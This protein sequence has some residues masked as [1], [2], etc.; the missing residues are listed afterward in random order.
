MKSERRD[1]PTPSGGDYSE[2]FYFDDN[3]NNVDK[4]VATK[5]VIKE[6]REDG[7][8]INEIFANIKI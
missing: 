5:A 1:R 4:T 6:C 2:V 7:T 3:G 8:V